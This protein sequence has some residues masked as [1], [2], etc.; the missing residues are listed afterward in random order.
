VEQRSG[1]HRFFRQRKSDS[2]VDGYEWDGVRFEI[3]ESSEEPDPDPKI[4]R[5]NVMSNAAV[6]TSWIDPLSVLFGDDYE[7][8]NRAMAREFSVQGR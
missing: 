2:K 1:V 7:T 8:A 6:H 3:D 4:R 5:L